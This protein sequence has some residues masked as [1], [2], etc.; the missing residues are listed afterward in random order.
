MSVPIQKGI[1]LHRKIDSYTDKH[2]EVKFCTKLLHPTQG[3][4]SPVVVDVL[5][6]YV[7]FHNWVRYSGIT[8][9]DFEI[10]VYDSIRR[11][12]DE[13]PDRIQKTAIAMVDGRFLSAYTT[14]EG[15]RKTFTR[16]ERRVKFESNIINAVDDLE[17]HFDAINEKFNQFFPDVIEMVDG[18]CEC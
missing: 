15:M 7:L 4:Y 3:K 18:F 2:K 8:Y 10:Q 1:E 5:F 17:F 13:F 14:L 6:D 16:M 9:D 12:I 11:G